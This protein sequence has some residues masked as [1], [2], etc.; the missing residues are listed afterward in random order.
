MTQDWLSLVLDRIP[1][2]AEAAPESGDAHWAQ[3][4]AEAGIKVPADY[5]RFAGAYGPVDLNDYVLF[6][7]P[8]HP[9]PAVNMAT[10]IEAF[11][12]TYE[13][14]RAAYARDYTPFARANSDFFCW[15]AVADDPDR[16][17]VSIVPREATGPIPIAASFS[18][19]MSKLVQNELNEFDLVA[20]FW[21]DEPPEF[22]S[23]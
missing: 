9:K 2:P 20:A 18:D 7:Y 23:V 1:V 10:Q 17:P 21:D 3:L 22:M 15:H 13:E 5:K 4:E 11:Q 12:R 16:W 8:G 6:F 14:L 19:F